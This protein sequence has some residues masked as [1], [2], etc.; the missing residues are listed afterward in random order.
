MMEQ[1]ALGGNK[2]K[3]RGKKVRKSKHHPIYTHDGWK[4]I[5]LFI[6]IYNG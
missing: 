4:H 6:S 5:Q 3:A 2:H 1:F